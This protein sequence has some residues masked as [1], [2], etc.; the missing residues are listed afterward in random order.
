[1]QIDF[2]NSAEA[3]IQFTFADGTQSP[4]VQ[5]GLDGI[6][7]MTNGVGLDRA[8]RTT[9]E[10]NHPVGLRGNWINAQAFVLEY[11]TVTNRYAYRI[12]ITFANNRLS[13]K[14]TERIYQS[15]VMLEGQLQN[16]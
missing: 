15:F 4:S 6:Y 9:L 5:I 11:E 13:I 10:I 3:N 14:I 16:P 2:N 12:E 7:R 8:F 1:M